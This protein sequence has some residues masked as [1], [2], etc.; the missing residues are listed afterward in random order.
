MRMDR[1]RIAKGLRLSL[2]LAATAL[3]MAA[4]PAEAETLSFKAD[5]R[6]V[7]GTN[8]TATG[9][10]TAN[11]DT[12]SKKLI[13]RGS[14][15]GIGTYATAATLFGPGNVPAVRLRSFDSPFRGTAILSEKQ[16]ADL[17]AGRWFI[18]IRTSAF[19]NGE[20]GGQI[21]K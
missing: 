15:H 4:A 2:F 19:P 14:Y 13:W 11:Y 17:M 9:A 5:L 6:A 7:A 16:A 8:S 21:V 20:L 18:L 10:F 3:A 1:E 12:D